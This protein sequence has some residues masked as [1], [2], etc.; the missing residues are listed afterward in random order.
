MILFKI[1]LL[2]VMIAVVVFVVLWIILEKE[3]VLL[4]I[5]RLV[6][7]DP[8]ETSEQR[9]VTILM[10]RAISVKLEKRLL[11]VVKDK[12]PEAEVTVIINKDILGGVV[13]QAGK[14]LIDSSLVNK[15]KRMWGGK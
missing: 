10:A 12:F 1:F 11:A 3:L 14:I 5:E 15:F 8:N 4:A 13:V 7:L 2:Q 9:E 6:H